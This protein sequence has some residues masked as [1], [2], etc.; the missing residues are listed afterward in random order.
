[1]LFWVVILLFAP[2]ILG[3]YDLGGL[4]DPVKDMVTKTLDMLPNVFAAFV[5]G[6]VGWIVGRVLSSLATNVLSAAGIDR[7]AGRIGLDESFR[8]SRLIGTI[9]F[10]FV[11]VPSL[12]AALDALKVETI[13]KPA[14]NMLGQMLGAVPNLIAAALILA[15]TFFVARFVSKLVVRLT[16]GLGIDTLPQKIGLAGLFSG[17][18]QPSKVVGALVLF[19]A[20]LFAVVEAANQLGFTQVRDVVTMFIRFAGDVLLGGVILVVG[21]WLANLAYAVIQRASGEHTTGLANL[22]RYAILGLV[23]AMGLRAMGI[24]DDIVNLAFAL[25]L[26]TV[27]LALALSFGLGGR[28]AAGRQMEYWLRKLRKEQ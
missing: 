20:M 16:S 22:A 1:M 4:L 6:F 7:A 15:I 21:F 2:A 5:I 3:A 10:I 8:L 11:F 19:F 9:V 14:T 28:E 26:G 18:T 27:A 13:S 24:A 23:F 25:T 17:A 12:I